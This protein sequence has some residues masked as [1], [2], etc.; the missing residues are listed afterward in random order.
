[1]SAVLSGSKRRAA[2]AFSRTWSVFFIDTQAA[3]IRSSLQIACS[4]PWNGV[5]FVRRAWAP[6]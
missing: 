2:S 3:L 1:M 6:S 5:S 4:R